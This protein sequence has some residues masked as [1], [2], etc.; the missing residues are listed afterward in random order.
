[1]QSTLRQFAQAGFLALAT[2][3]LCVVNGSAQEPAQSGAADLIRALGARITP[4]YENQNM[5]GVR[6][7]Q[8]EPHGRLSQMS[9]VEGEIILELDGKP[10]DSPSATATMLKRMAR[11]EGMEFLVR[12]PD[13][14]L[15]KMRVTETRSA[16]GGVTSFAV[17]HYEVG[18]K[19]FRSPRPVASPPPLVEPE[20][21]VEVEPEPEDRRKFI[22]VYENDKVIGARFEDPDG[23]GPTLPGL[24]PGDVVTEFDGR[25]VDNEED[26]AALSEAIGRGSNVE[27]IF[28]DGSGFEALSSLS[29]ADSP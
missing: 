2:C 14:Q 19:V 16:G 17:E 20:P 15:R 11:G 10:L 27:L 29:F 1:M 23:L 18:P 13:G 25:I 7:T 4:Y 26:V 12:R 28:R 21:E 3:V 5:Q 24:R 9:F 6:L 22:S 8:V